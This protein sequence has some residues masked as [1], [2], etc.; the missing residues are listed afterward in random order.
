[1]VAGGWGCGE[2]GLTANRYRILSGGDENVLEV[3]EVRFV[4]LYQCANCH[5]PAR[6]KTVNFG[7]P[8]VPQWVK[9]PTL[10]F[11]FKTDDRSS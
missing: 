11:S 3:V 10:G 4:R 9:H 5:Y 7:V 2:W 8:R 6:F 1:M